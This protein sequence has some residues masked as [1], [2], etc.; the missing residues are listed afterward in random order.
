MQSQQTL[1]SIHQRHLPES[2]SISKEVGFAKNTH[3]SSL[4]LNSL[5]CH[6]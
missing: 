3:P 1:S 4:P 5:L 6:F 2:V